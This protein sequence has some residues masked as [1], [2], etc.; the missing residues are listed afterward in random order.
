[1]LVRVAIVATVV[2]ALLLVHVGSR[3]GVRWRLVTFTYQA[4]LLA[5]LFYTWT[6]ISP[7]ADA[8]A[9]LRG[10][11]VMYVVVAGLIWNAFLTDMSMGYTVAN[12]LLHIAMP[13]LVLT[14]WVLVGRAQ[15]ALRWW[16]PLVW[17]AYPAGYLLA[18]LLVLNHLGRRAPYYF[19][20][21]AGIGA[22]GVTLNVSLLA[23]MFLGLGYGLVA[24]GR[25]RA[26]QAGVMPPVIRSDAGRSR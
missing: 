9:G 12:V 13:L 7:R 22:V 8:R 15:T 3:W 26:S 19:L 11:V 14:E 5:A 1:M 25:S 21:P 4:N 23:V 24:F 18:A 20:D 10:A 6:L 17:L 2:V 16:Q